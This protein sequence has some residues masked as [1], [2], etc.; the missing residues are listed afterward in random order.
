VGYKESPQKMKI[1]RKQKQE[2][3]RGLIQNILNTWKEAVTKI[4]TIA[5]KEVKD[6][7]NDGWIYTLG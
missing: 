6:L 7:L 2:K 4:T 3:G 5:E 1:I